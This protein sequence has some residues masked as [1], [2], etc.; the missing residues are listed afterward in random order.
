MGLLAR[1]LLE[2]APDPWGRSS[3]SI[4]W[5]SSGSRPSAG[6]ASSS[7]MRPTS[8]TLRSPGSSRPGL[9]RGSPASTATDS[10][11]LAGRAP[12]PLD[13]GGIHADAA[14]HGVSPQGGA[15]VRL[16][17]WHWIA[18]SVLTASVIFHVVHASV[19][20]TSAP[21]GRTRSTCR[22]PGGGRCAPSAVL[23]SRRAN[24]L[25]TRSRTS[26]TTWPSR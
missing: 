18:G 7:S 11:A 22:T 8:A 17:T 1:S 24:S 26:S 3:P 5:F 4:S 12:V 2:W 14:D 25:S 9:A 13:H 19:W 15:A 16:V 6:S 23:P 21:S 10:P 20:L